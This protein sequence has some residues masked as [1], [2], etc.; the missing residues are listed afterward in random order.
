MMVDK[1]L[2]A[3]QHQADESERSHA[4]LPPL[5][6]LLLAA[7]AQPGPGAPAHRHQPRGA[8]G[9]F[10][11]HLPGQALPGH[12]LTNLALVKSSSLGL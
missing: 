6:P 10:S 7:L 12:R 5:H 2:Q 8:K 4:H 11:V 1:H 3:D 9:S